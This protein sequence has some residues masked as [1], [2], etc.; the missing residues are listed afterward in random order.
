MREFAGLVLLGAEVLLNRLL[1]LGAP[2]IIVSWIV[3][4]VVLITTFIFG[5]K[6]LKMESPA[7]LAAGGANVAA[8]SVPP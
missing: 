5:Q 4:P 1:A 2:G 6:V 3:T 8:P 7:L